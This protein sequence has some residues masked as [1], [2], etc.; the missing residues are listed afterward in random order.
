MRLTLFYIAIFIMAG[1]FFLYSCQKEQFQLD[2]LSDEIE[3]HTNLVAPLIHGSMGMGEIVAEFDSSGY[4]GEF[5]DGLIYLS[6]VDTLVNV[7][8]DTLHLM[9]DGLYTQIYFDTEIA[10]DPEFIGSA[11]GDTIHFIKSKYFGF[12]TSGDNRFDSIVFKGGEF[13]TEIVSTFQH[14]G[15]LTISSEY[16]WDSN[17]DPYTYTVAISDPSG[18]FT[19]SESV[20]LDGYFLKA[21][22]QGDSSIFR[23]DYDFAMINSG[24]PVNPGDFCE[25]NS[26]FLDMEFY[27][28]FGYLDPDDVVSE[29]G[30]IDIPIY[31]DFPELT[32]LKLADPRISIYTE[33]SLGIPFELALDSVIGTAEDGST[34]TLEFYSGHPFIIPAP[35]IDMLGETAYGAFYINN[36]TSNIQDLLNIAPHTLSYKV[37]GDVGSQNPSHFL[38]DTSRFMTEMEFLL[39]LDLA[40]T[41][42]SLSDTME[43]AL[44]E[45]GVDTSFVKNVVVK[46]S[47]VNE[48]PIE[49]GLQ[50]YLLDISETVLDSLFNGD[51][52]F[53][54]SSEVDGEGKLLNASETS[55]NINFP[56]EKLGTLEQTE[57]LWI[58]ARMVTAESGVPFVKFYSDYTLD[59]EISFYAELRINNREL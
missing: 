26:S 6:Y 47:T 1:G 33:S 23:M 27:K 2:K 13:L 50:V 41:E 34:E 55:H 37:T 17:G 51:P 22:Q 11:P 19:W 4:V 49:L 29:S 42:Y 21:D 53:L 43:F 52:V 7:M 38:L 15:I 40:F 35:T 54:A 30:V 16:I 39:P 57:F 25:I 32:H 18:N 24:N 45:E 9:I 58:K 3:I 48:V 14:A 36:Q 59:F 44:V 56:A 28:L 12:E 20:D 5:E 31:A 8:V 46:L 10:G